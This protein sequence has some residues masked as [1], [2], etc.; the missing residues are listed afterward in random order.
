MTVTLPLYR[1]A[2]RRAL[3]TLAVVTALVLAPVVTGPAA[4]GGAATAGAATS[5]DT[6]TAT[7]VPAPTPSIAAT[8]GATPTP[9]PTPTAEL[10]AD[11]VAFTLAPVGNGILEA[12]QNLTASVSL[13]NEASVAVAGTDVALFLGTRPLAD[14]AALASWLGGETSRVATREVAET[15]FEPLLAGEA[16]V[17]G[18]TVEADDPALRGL[19]PGVY[20]L[21]ASFTAGDEVVS[22]TSVITVP[23]PEAEAVDVGLVV[24]LTA[25]ALTEGLLTAE[26]LETLT[27]PGGALADQLD[28]VDGSDAILAVDPAIA[29][30][31]RVLGIAAPETARE[32]LTRLE[33]LPN[34][35][36]ALQFGDADVAVQL[37]A[38]T[39]TPLQPRALTAYIDPENFVGGPEPTALPTPTPTPTSDP[40]TPAVPDLDALLAVGEARD[41]VYWPARGIA[42]DSVVAELGDLGDDETASLT[43]LNS[44]ATR[45][46]VDGR[47][48]PARGSAGDAAVVVYDADISAA[49]TEAA[50]LDETLPRGAALTA[51]TAHLAFAADEAGGRPVAI[52]LDR[53]TERSR[54]GLGTAISAITQAPGVRAVDLDTL[55]DAA[56]RPVAIADSDTDEERRAA[57][58][59]LLA[60]E[61]DLARFATILDDSSL[62]TGPERA[63]ILQLLGTAWLSQPFAF[64]VAVAEHRL[65][66]RATIGSVELLPTSDITLAGSTADLRFWVRNDLPYPVELVLYASPDDLRLN[67]QRATPII[68]TAQSNT[69]VVVPVQARLGSGDVALD[70][71][72]R[73]PSAIAVGSAERVNVNVRAEWEGVGIVAL[74]V[75]VGVMLVLGA[76]RTVLRVRARRARRAEV[77]RA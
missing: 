38:G 37:A 8:P 18:L 61:E 55:T 57:A 34:P 32:W 56:P 5:A 65:A 40:E 1:R 69:R 31:I 63:E 46:G 68:A 19:D 35:R 7:P 14:R 39:G 71:Q 74:S 58:S 47:T 23:D 54:V 60:A 41:D 26:E 9:T 52:A 11:A 15:V 43:L 20:P 17:R 64:D 28:A 59:A 6:A 66:T 62:L 27:A 48:V 49:L 21:V 50:A 30:A 13:T 77:T 44:R 24:P 25:G 16:V 36:F 2:A 3:A 51:A 75:I 42:P 4:A 45:Q 22:S 29:A 33:A 70:L 73:S 72:L 67:V 12:G 10:S 53:S 76:I